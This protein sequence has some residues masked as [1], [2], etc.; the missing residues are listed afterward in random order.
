MEH[1]GWVMFGKAIVVALWLV[2]VERWTAFRRARREN[3]LPMKQRRDG[4][5]VVSDWTSLIERAFALGRDAFF[6][7]WIAGM[8]FLVVGLVVLGKARFGAWL[9]S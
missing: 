5:Y 2:V 3:G 9:F 1:L 4:V 7:L 6:W 8:T